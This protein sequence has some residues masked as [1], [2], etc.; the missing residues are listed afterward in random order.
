[1]PY[2]STCGRAP[3][4]SFGEAVIRGLAPDGGLYLPVELPDLPAECLDPGAEMS[5]AERAFRILRRYVDGDVEDHELQRVC[6]GAFDF[7][8]PLTAV[9]ESVYAL[10]LFWGPTFAFKDFG[11]RFLARIIDAMAVRGDRRTTIL[12]A[13]SGD[14]G[15]AVAHGFFGMEAVD[16]VLLYPSG[17][18]STLQEQQLTTVG[19]NVVALE[20][21]GTFDDCQRLVK[22]AFAD[23]EVSERRPLSSANS[24]SIGRLLPQIVYWVDASVRLGGGPDAPA[25]ICVPSGNYGNVTGALIASLTG[26]AVER[27]VIGSNA[28]DSVPR[29]LANGVFEPRATIRTPA[30]AMDVGN[31]S[32]LARIRALLG[33]DI[34]RVRSLF[35]GYSVS[36]PE[37]LSTIGDVYRRHGLVLDP[38]SAVGFEALR[39]YREE[40]REVTG[41]AFFAATAH[42]AKFAEAIVEATGRE[43][44]IPDRLSEALEKK[45]HAIRIGADFAELRSYLIDTAE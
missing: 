25:V 39:R 7:P 11:A 34:E 32:N 45:K 24:I 16:V 19:G 17:R 9:G 44:E 31:P 14:T 1:M 13:T 33:D 3:V 18:V 43:V 2:S 35:R 26:L 40:H 28:N 20:V 5:Y 4:V 41:P 27:L 10:E 29:Y 30:N 37:I 38:H 21:D 23:A 22:T 6:T 8:V 15:S 42:P 12:V 36:T